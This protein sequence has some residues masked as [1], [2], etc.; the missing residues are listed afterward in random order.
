MRIVTRPDF[1]GV[2]CA[3]LLYEAESIDRPVKWIE[4]SEI[5]KGEGGIQKGDIIAN[6]PYH[7]DCSLWFDHH[8]SNTLETPFA[9]AFELAPSAAGIVYRY[10]RKNL[11]RDY[12]ELIRQTDRI[13]SADLTMAEVMHPEKYDH[14]LLSMTV[15]GRRK[16]DEPYW[17]LL[18][19]LL[20]KSAMA[21]IMAQAEVSRRCRRVIDDN[22][23]YKKSLEKYTRVEKKTAITDFRSLD[24]TPEGNRFLVYSLFPETVV[25][26]RISYADEAKQIVSLQAGH[27]IFNRHCNVNIGRL[28]ARFDGGGHE[29]AGACRFPVDRADRYIPQILDVLLKNEADGEAGIRK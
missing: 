8:V 20:R 12:S 9:G 25:S 4:P 2:V 22:A 23:E 6:L 21:E 26:I 14:V 24:R 3:A 17:N 15:S 18:V 11:K 10:Y 29:G 28:L 5:Q 7:P 27:S 13:D 16:T 1:D 19:A